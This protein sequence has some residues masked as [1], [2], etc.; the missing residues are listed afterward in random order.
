M[1]DH[2]NSVDLNGAKWGSV[3]VSGG[4]WDSVVAQWGSVGFSGGQW[5]S[6]GSVELSGVCG[7]QCAMYIHPFGIN[8][9]HILSVS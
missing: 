5:A 3:G 2:R 8:S 6:V 7:D 1:R 4:Q 9:F